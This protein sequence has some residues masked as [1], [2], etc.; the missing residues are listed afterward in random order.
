[1]M[2][3]SGKLVPATQC[4][5]ISWP[6]GWPKVLW[7]RRM[8]GRASGDNAAQIMG[9]GSVRSCAMHAIVSWCEALNGSVSLQSALTELVSGLGAE[10]GVIVRT[11]MND[12]RPVRIAMCDL[13]RDT[14][15]RPLQRTFAD[16][17]FGP[18]I[19]RARSATVWHARAH[20]DDSTGDPS[21]AVWQAARKMKEFVALI[22][23]S[24]TQTRDH[25]ELHFRD[26]L[27]PGCE[28]TIAAML[29]DMVRV[30]ASRKVGLITRSIINH[31]PGESLGFRG[32]TK[33]KVLDSDNPL[34]LSR[35]EF[36]VCLLLGRGLRVQAV[37]S[38]LSLS[39][40]TIRTH[41]RKIGRASCRERV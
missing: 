22:L 10:A 40:A 35:A 36:R 5:V 29:P 6:D 39:E 3:P 4:F 15:H 21:L 12:Q 33:E 16:A 28:S 11:Q 31:R 14:R 7:G 23:S 26:F 2:G 17:Y 19:H 20:A 38:E 1:M 30:W 24:G 13:A 18:L 9:Q 25:I 34:R 41:L 32:G 8:I 37:A 27:S